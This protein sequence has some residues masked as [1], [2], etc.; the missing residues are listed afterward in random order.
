LCRT[1]KRIT[2]FK[3]LPLHCGIKPRFVN[4]QGIGEISFFLFVADLNRLCL[5]IVIQGPPYG[6]AVLETNIGFLEQRIKYANY[7]GFTQPVFFPLLP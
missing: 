6:L 3:R 2:P 4:D 5:S 1:V 7:R